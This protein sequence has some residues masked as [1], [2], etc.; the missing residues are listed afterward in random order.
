[1]V[2]H[3]ENYNLMDNIFGLVLGTGLQVFNV[4]LA[5]NFFKN[6][7]VELEEAC[8]VDGGGPWRN[9]ISIYVPLAKPMVATVALFTMVM[10]WNEFFQGMVLSTRQTSYPLQTY[11]QQM[12]VTL[13]YS[14]MNVDQ[15]A[16]AMKLN[17]L[18]LDSAKNIY[19]YDTCTDRLPV[20][21]KIF[22]RVLHWDQ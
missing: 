3:H 1:M 5:V 9:L 11:I 10:Y 22:C 17:N 6:L 16:Q 12:V 8:F 13:D 19:S 2:Y 18:S 15:I 20:P 14:T 4:I 7:P 21:A